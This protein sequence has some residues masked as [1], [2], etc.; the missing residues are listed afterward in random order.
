MLKLLFFITVTVECKGGYYF[1]NFFG[2]KLDII[3]KVDGLFI[4]ARNFF[5]FFSGNFKL[6]WRWD[7][8][9][10]TFTKE[11]FD[12]YVKFVF[13]KID[14]YK[15]CGVINLQNANT[16]YFGDTDGRVGA[17]LYALLV[18]GHIGIREKG[19]SLLCEL[20]KHE[21]M[22]L[23]AYKHKNNKVLYDLLNTRDMILN[24]LH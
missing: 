9:K 23:F 17:V 21:E 1:I 22:A 5:T 14:F 6:D 20:L 16:A 7:V 18:L 19:W 2:D 8:F 10:E 13:L 3:Y 15:Q 12:S 24:E 11:K 4:I